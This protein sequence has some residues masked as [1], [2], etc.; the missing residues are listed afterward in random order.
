MMTE[1][2]RAKAVEDFKNEI[3]GAATE[4]YG[5]RFYEQLTSICDFY[6]KFRGGFVR[7]LEKTLDDKN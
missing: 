4:V 1:E 5:S 3:R 2:Q 7:S 6:V